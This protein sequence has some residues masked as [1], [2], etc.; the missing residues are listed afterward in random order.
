MRVRAPRCLT[1]GLVALLE[2][3]LTAG[4]TATSL[5]LFQVRRPRHAGGPT[6]ARTGGSGQCEAARRAA[7]ARRPT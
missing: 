5:A 3:P 4:A 2:V 7:R 1:F 6:L